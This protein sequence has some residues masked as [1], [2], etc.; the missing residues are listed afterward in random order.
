M[1]DW[2]RFWVCC[3]A[4]SSSF[5]ELPTAE[6]AIPAWLTDQPSDTRSQSLCQTAD[7][8]AITAACKFGFRF[9]ACDT[10]LSPRT[11]CRRRSNRRGRRGWGYSIAGSRGRRWLWFGSIIIIEIEREIGSRRS[12]RSSTNGSISRRGR[13]AG[14][15]CVNTGGGL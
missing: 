14:S 9:F 12:I 2:Q 11:P 13:C 8:L 5:L 4:A 10:T 7:R 3:A 15:N 6:K 1:H